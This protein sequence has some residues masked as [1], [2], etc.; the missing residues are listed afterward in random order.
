MISFF[1]SK[2]DD[3]KIRETAEQALIDHPLVKRSNFDI[4]SEEGILKILNLNNNN[5]TNKAKELIKN[6]L[7]TSGVKYERIET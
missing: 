3:D 5:S 1:G 7:E 2:Y 4:V 6:K